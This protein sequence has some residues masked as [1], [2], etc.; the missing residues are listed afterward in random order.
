MLNVTVHYR[1]KGRVTKMKNTLTI[2]DFQHVLQEGQDELSAMLRRLGQEATPED[3][4]VAADISKTDP[5]T[6]WVGW[7]V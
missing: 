6:T 2:R 1:E 5:V 3:I 4:Q 7:R